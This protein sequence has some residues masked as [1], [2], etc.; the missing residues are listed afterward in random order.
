MNDEFIERYINELVEK[1]FFEVICDGIS[2]QDTNYRVVFQNQI[3]KN[4]IG[5]HL[6]EFCYKA[7]EKREH[8]C[9]GCPVAMAFKDGK[10]H[11]EERSALTENG[12]SYFEITASPLKD[13]DGQVIAGIEVVR[14]ITN[15]R[16][17]QEEIIN[18]SKFP[19][20]NPNPVLRISDTGEV[21]FKNQAVISLLEMNNL[22]ERDISRILPQNLK[23]IIS[24]TIITKNPQNDIEV[25]IGDRIY[26][27]SL[28]P[29]ADN[30]YIN[31]YGADITDRKKYEHSLIESE[32]KYRNLHKQAIQDWSDT[33]ETIPDMITIHDRDFN[34]MRANK[35]ANEILNL[36]I[37]DQKT[38]NKCFK[39]YHGTGAPP[40]DCPSC[41][42]YKTG[43]PATF[44]VFEPHLNKF[45]EIRAIPRFNSKKQLVGLIH[46]VRDISLRK[47]WEKKLETSQKELQN[48]TA[49][50][51]S[52]REEERLHIAR[53]IHDE[54]AQTL[55]LLHI[56]LH[57]LDRQLPKNLASLHEITGSMT[58]AINSSIN[59]VRKIT[60]DLRPKLLDDLGLKAAIKWH[61]KQLKKTGAI[62]CEV[63]LDFQEHHIHKNQAIT[64]FRIFQEALT[65]VIRHANASRVEV[66]LKEY[67]ANLLIAVHDDG[68]GIKKEQIS[69]PDSLGLIGLRER[70]HHF[71]GIIK[72]SGATDQGTTISVSIPLDIEMENQE[73]TSNIGI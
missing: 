67:A 73:H 17:A 35:A 69:S 16:K 62:E 58:T 2:I 15:R 59:T 36:P 7:Y 39:Y 25:N 52:I 57:N 28:I 10:P 55:T 49:H 33:F 45:I 38:I 20:E 12:M 34:L 48:L 19:S 6:G 13:I 53:E 50:L 44:E 47:D 9:D 71:N 30:L 51:F 54:L 8:V 1:R 32:N 11:T 4:F 29:V 42:C 37:L 26:S 27:Y 40:E 22:S 68:V 66:T 24:R 5:E 3:H 23:E 65:N 70:V 46:I 43:E 14:D 64:V 56:E 41:N 21:L 61:V 72:I 18:L 60:S 31:M 63:S